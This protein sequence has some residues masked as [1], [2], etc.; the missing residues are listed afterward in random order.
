MNPLDAKDI[1]ATLGTL[2]VLAT[3][4]IETGLLVGLFLPG[5]SLLFVAGIAA[6]GTA[7][8]IFG[9][10]LSYTQLMIWAPIAATAG[11]QCGHWLGAKYGRPFFDRP[12]TRFFNQERVA[13]TERWLMKYGL[14]KALILS[15]FIPLVRT[16]INPLCGI[17]GVSARKFFIW[18]II[19]SYIWTVSLISTGYLLGEQLE[20]FVDKYLLPIVALII[21]LSLAPI[22]IEYLRDRKRRSTTGQDH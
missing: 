10:Q 6:S 8:E 22:T 9:N 14:G 19:G 7:K 2:G 11:S 16:I 17:I 21:A 12:N 4:F 18:N 13:Q 15:R 5:D 3:L 20:G 1:V